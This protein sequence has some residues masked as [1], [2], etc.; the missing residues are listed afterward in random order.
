MR[1]PAV[2]LAILGLT[3]ST[4]L[5]STPG[6][7]NAG[8]YTSWNNG[9]N[10]GTGFGAW[11]LSSNNNNNTTEFA[12]YFLGSSTD[13]TGNLN[14]AG[15]SFGMYANPG[16]AFSNAARSL[17]GGALALGQNFS[18]TLGVNFRNGNKG[19]DLLSGA[20]TV[21][22]FNVGADQYFVNGQGLAIAY[23]PDSVFTLS[24][25]PTSATTLLVLVTRS[26]SAGGTEVAF[27]NTVTVTGGDAIDG[28]KLYVSGTENGS[29]ANNLYFN[30]I[31]VGA[32]PEPATFAW[33]A[34]GLGG[35]L[36]LRRRRS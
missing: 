3:G 15:Q 9:S 24:L 4:L 27:S 34:A 29:S 33:I 31:S 18:I 36:V 30:S 35:M 5:A 14:T 6:S 20:S 22:N 32:I 17:T 1:S 28:F 8:N 26:S 21:F 10:Q 16:S 23:Q 25:T 2:L 13:G 19:I 12:G 7:D 11:D